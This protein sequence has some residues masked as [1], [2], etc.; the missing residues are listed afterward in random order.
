MAAIASGSDAP[1]IS[2]NE[3]SLNAPSMLNAAAS[4]SRSIQKMPNRLLSGMISPGRMEY[5]YSGDSAIPTMRSRRRR[6]L[7][8][9]ATLAPGRK[10]WASAK[11]SLASTSSGASGRRPRRRNGSFRMGCSRAGIEMSR[12]VAGSSKSGRSSA[13]STTIRGVTRATP[14]IAARSSATNSGARLTVTN[15]SAKRKRS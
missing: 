8:V 6:P 4:E 12:P 5:T 15:T 9:A 2:A 7:M 13:T 1:R 14:G 10:L 3:A 11:P